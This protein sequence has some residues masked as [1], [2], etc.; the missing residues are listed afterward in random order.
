MS[1]IKTIQVENL[2]SLQEFNGFPILKTLL[3][4][5]IGDDINKCDF[6]SVQ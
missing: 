5:E 6:D 3:K 1:M 4:S 2:F